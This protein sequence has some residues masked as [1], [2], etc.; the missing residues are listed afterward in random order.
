MKF[1]DHYEWKN[2]SVLFAL[3]L[4]TVPM[5]KFP[6]CKGELK[7]YFVKLYFVRGIPQHSLLLLCFYLESESQL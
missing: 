4:G 2:T 1:P 3:I 7:W 6:V 5:L